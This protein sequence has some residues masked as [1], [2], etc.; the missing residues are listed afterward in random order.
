MSRF[1]GHIIKLPANTP[2]QSSAPGVWTLKDQLVAQRNNQW[3]FQRDPDFRYT[4]LLL[5]GNV[6]NTTGPQAMNL[7]LS[8]NADA[9]TNNFLVT[10]NG[11]VGPRP[12]SP[13]FG[14]NYSVYFSGAPFI[15]APDN[16]SMQFGATDFTI[17]FWAYFPNGFSGSQWIGGKGDQNTIAGSAFSLYASAFDIY[18]GSSTYTLSCPTWLAGRWYHVAIVR[19]G[20]GSNNLK[21][22]IDGNLHSQ[23]SIGS[24]SVNSASGNGFKVGAYSSGGPVSYISNFRIVKGR[25]VYTSAFSPSLVAL[26][27][28]SGGQNP[29]Q[30]TETSLLICQSNRF[31]DNSVANSGTGWSLT[32][33]STPSITDNSPFV[34]TDF[35]TGAG[36]FTGATTDYFRIADNASLDMGSGS[37]TIECFYYPAVSITTA[38][39]SAVFGKRATGG[40]YG[41]VTGEFYET[42]APKFVST[43][44]GSSWGV[45]IT[46]SILCVQNQWNHIAWVR[47]GDAWT[48]YVNGQAGGSVNLAGTIPDNTADF[49][50][51]ATE[52]SASSYKLR[53]GY[54]SDFRVVKGAAVY[55]GNFTPPSLG[56]LRTSGAASAAAYPSTTNVNT[57][58]AES[59]TS[60]LTLQTRAPSQNINF[61]DSSPN[62]F[63]VTRN[64]NVS[65]GT[66]SPFSPSGWGYYLAEQQNN[67]VNFTTSAGTDFQF[68]GDFT[69]EGWVYPQN[70]SGD[71]SLFVVS[72]NTNYLA[73]NISISANVF[74][75]YLN[76]GT[77]AAVIT[78]DIPVAAW[79]HVAMVRNGSGTGNIK[80][81]VNGG[82][83]GSAT[84]TST[85]GFA[86]PAVCRI[87]GGVSGINR[88][89]S[90]VRVCKSAVYTAAFTPSTLPLSTTSQGATN[91]VLL[92]A[93]ANR[94]LNQTAG[95]A[96]TITGSPSVQAFSPFAP[97][98][99]VSPLVT[100]GSGYF[101]GST[102]VWLVAPDNPAL[103]LS[104]NDFTIECWVY[105]TADFSANRIFTS[106]WNHFVFGINS[107]PA[108]SFTWY[109]TTNG[110]ATGTLIST[111]PN[112]WHHFAVCRQGGTLYMFQNGQ[113]LTQSNSTITGTLNNDS[114]GPM[115]GGNENVVS[116]AI[117]SAN[118]PWYGYISGYRMV[119]GTALYTSSFPIPTAPPTAIPGTSLLLN[120]TG[121]GIVD[122]TGKNV[123]ETFGN[124]Q[125]TTAQP[126]WTGQGSLS[127]N[128]AAGARFQ[129]SSNSA[130]PLFNVGTGD[131]TVEFWV[132]TG[133]PASQQCILDFRNAD[134]AGQGY[135]LIF[136]T[137]RQIIMYYNVG[138]RITTSAISANVW[139]HIAV[140]RYNGVYTIYVNGSASGGTYNNS[141]AVAP[142]ANRPLI[143][144]VSDG[145]QVFNGNFSDF[146]IS[147]IARYT[148]N[149]NINT[150]PGP[151]P[152][153]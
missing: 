20:S 7:P 22:W 40:T 33:S 13:Y 95:A 83:K 73:L 134:V 147:R 138:N 108:L 24:N 137:S 92:T 38:Q 104:S 97:A 141:D 23:V 48:I 125:L 60:L 26:G 100:G 119:N 84:N 111:A 145:S 30:G 82:L 32:V 9:S 39:G 98:N 59:A 52:S 71:G 116:G 114:Y 127:N 6:P 150:I 109:G 123:I 37:F 41:G 136:N 25:A 5:Q 93:N 80:L 79:T 146:R 135:A 49:T 94:F 126:K 55:T 122:A 128:G 110:S 47:N 96:A 64:G 143:G 21:L 112:A 90:N 113:K 56:M 86:N 58:F 89:Y 19:S 29:P 103:E 31:I 43:V 131:Y 54:L 68:S 42:Y 8:Y 118:E 44:N 18:A 151:F 87:G 14:G 88:Y 62:E 76:G 2:S 130:P 153:G 17:E 142:P 77:P 3:P 11:D 91:C 63:I 61:I 149:F 101:P 53:Q 51:G 28:T 1:P 10:P 67:T 121:G 144:S 16:A 34:S 152:I 46:S 12:F 70:S 129:V 72:D 66:F 27:A 117:A 99:S 45:N 81:Y 102:S 139:T 132:N 74:N 124:A 75:I 120:F 78:S 15:Q 69:I 65:Q 57:S 140:V 105:S 50:I 85:L 4:T 115:L 35:T 106:K 107:T 133:T 148:G 36:Y